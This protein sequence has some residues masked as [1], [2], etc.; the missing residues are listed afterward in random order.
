MIY[1]YLF[2]TTLFS[3]P[4]ISYKVPA[5]II[6]LMSVAGTDALFAKPYSAMFLLGIVAVV[7][8]RENKTAVKYILVFFLLVLAL[9]FLFSIL[10]GS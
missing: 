6:N 9:E 7:T 3:Y 8:N 1:W 10:F 4:D 5:T 2:S